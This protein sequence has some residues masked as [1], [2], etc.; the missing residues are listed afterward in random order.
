MVLCGAP[1]SH[2]LTALE[3]LV[4]AC[5]LCGGAWQGVSITGYH[6]FGSKVED[7]VLNNLP[8]PT[9]MIA[10]ANFCVFIHVVGAS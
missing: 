1:C 4:A 6:A 10:L 5:S 2:L 8:G 3:V 7:N 9:W